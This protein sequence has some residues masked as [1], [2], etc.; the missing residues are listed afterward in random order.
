[1][2]PLLL[3]GLLALGSVG[4][5]GCLEETMPAAATDPELAAPAAL[6]AVVGSKCIQAGGNSVYSMQDGQ[7]KIG[8]FYAADQRPEIGNPT[9]G[10]FG[11]PM[12]GPANGIWHVAV[13][14]ESYVF[15]GETHPGFRMGWIAQMIKRPDF[16]TDGPRLQFF[17]AD[18]SFDNID[19]VSQLKMLTAGAEV[20]PNTEA[21]I[22]LFPLE[23]Y[24]HVVISEESHGTFD[25]TA[26]LHKE[27]AKK[28]S[29]KIRFWMLVATDGS[30][31][32][33][34]ELAEP[35]MYRPIAI[36]LEDVADGTG[37]KIAGE[38]IGTFTHFP[39]GHF[40]NPLGHL[41]TGFSRTI[42]LGPMPDGILFDKTWLH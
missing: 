19:F 37:K 15:E 21:S 35:T 42:T 29:E 17:V 27:F 18:L 13:R 33:D 10:A 30:H 3:F 28:E 1:M 41:Q 36:D 6:P 26:E 39:D 20:S 2:K 16:D 40:G 8:P 38:S 32:H 14:C 11:A 31:H 22:E 34:G 5:A 23:K 7:T 24:M 4:F 12:T 25:F 9:I